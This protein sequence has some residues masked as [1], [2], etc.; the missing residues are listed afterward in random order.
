MTQSTRRPRDVR[1][2]SSS[3]CSWRL[4]TQIICFLL[5][6]M[7]SSGDLD[8]KHS[9]CDHSLITQASIEVLSLQTVQQYMVYLGRVCWC[10]TLVL[11][12][13]TAGLR[14]V[15]RTSALT[16][17]PVERQRTTSTSAV[18]QGGHGDGWIASSGQ[19]ATGQQPV[20]LDAASQQI[21]DDHNILRAEHHVG[22]LQWDADLAAGAAQYAAM[23]LFSHDPNNTDGEN[24]M[25]T[26]IIDSD[27]LTYY[28]AAVDMW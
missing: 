23:C 14:E 22:P 1:S 16:D 5:T 6:I 27:V 13:I 11:S 24:I 8:V 17:A 4:P 2:T 21:L 20:Q 12:T 25:A 3:G 10:L 9:E 28:A 7:A 18:S 19:V 26:S 15:S